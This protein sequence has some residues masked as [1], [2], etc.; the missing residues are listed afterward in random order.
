VNPVPAAAQAKAI[1]SLTDD[2]QKQ[3]AFALYFGIMGT[4]KPEPAWK[5]FGPSPRRP[6]ERPNTFAQAEVLLEMFPE[7]RK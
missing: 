7:F 6:V 3:I 4:A 2:P 5:R 1:R